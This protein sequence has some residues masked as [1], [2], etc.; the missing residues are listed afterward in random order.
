MKKIV[1]NTLVVGTQ[2]IVGGLFLFMLFS[3][4]SVD[5][6]V[7]LVNNNN[8]NKMSDAVNELF[9]IE[10]KIIDMT[11]EEVLLGAEE[12]KLLEE[13]VIEIHNEEVVVE[14]P[15]QE[16]IEDVEQPVEEVVV[17][18]PE[19]APVPEPVVVV[20]PSGY[21]SNA[22]VGFNVTT[23]NKTYVLSD[24]DFAM[25]ATV[26]NCEANRSSKDDILGVVSVILNRADSSR[27]PND[28]VAVVAAPHQFSCYKGV[29]N[30]NVSDFV[31]A[32]VRDALN[33]IR[34][35]NYYGFRSW[36]ST[37]Y[38]NNYIVERGNRYA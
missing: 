30:H 29:I 35:N 37:G 23:G 3:G 13:E 36:S 10:P 14:Q 34:N 7:V 11:K 12:L 5:K 28:P 26:V 6:K 27:Y 18:V 4:T 22:S 24:E 32:V 33:G 19:P 9:V 20:D 15:V 8:L 17:P 38:S 2:L 21:I 16:V 31:K 25:L 1:S